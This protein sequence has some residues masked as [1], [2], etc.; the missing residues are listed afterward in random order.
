M[1]ITC[2]ID[3]SE[4]HHDV[5]LADSDGHTVAKQRITT[6]LSGF[7]ELLTL[8]AEHTDNPASVPVA[9]ETDKNLIVAALQAAGF[10][11]YAINPR[12]VARYRERH[13]QAGN[14]SDPGDAVVLANVLR[15]DRHRIERCPKSVSLGWQSKR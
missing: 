7:T 3:W 8:L 6:T 13:G 9:I 2:G 11:V 1:S 12:A 10:T 15:T 14:K 4:R 5:A